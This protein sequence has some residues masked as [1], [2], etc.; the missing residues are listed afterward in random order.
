MDVLG[1]CWLGGWGFP[2]LCLA[3]PTVSQLH[4]D[5]SLTNTH[6]LNRKDGWVNGKVRAVSFAEIHRKYSTQR[7]RDIA[8]TC[9]P[10][11]SKTYCTVLKN[12]IHTAVIYT[13][14]HTLYPR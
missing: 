12:I 11:I 9:K 3:A 7:E 1:A 14:T 4:E 6:C 5:V 13:H 10:S 8:N 2:R